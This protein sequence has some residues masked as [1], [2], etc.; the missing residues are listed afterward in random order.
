MA[1][2]KP[3]DYDPFAAGPKFTPVDDDPFAG[4]TVTP[5]EHDPFVGAD[6][7]R[8]RG[9]GAAFSESLRSTPGT[10]GAG[11]EATGKTIGSDI[12]SR[13]GQ[14]LEEKT[15]TE[16]TGFRPLTWDDIHGIGDAWDWLKEQA[17]SGIASTIPSVAS[18]LAGAGAGGLIG[19]VVP[20]VGTAA[21][22]LGGG[23]AGAASTAVP[24]NI[25]DAYKQF[26][27]EGIDDETAAKAGTIVG[28]VISIPDVFSSLTLTKPFTNTAKKAATDI[29]I[30]TIAQRIKS[31]MTVEAATEGLQQLIQEAAAAALG[32]DATLGQ[33]AEN[34]VSS[35][36][37]GGLGGATV[38]TGAGI[39][40]RMTSNPPPPTSGPPPA[41]DATAATGAPIPGTAGEPSPPA[42]VATIEPGAVVGVKQKDAPPVRAQIEGVQDGY[43]FWRDDDG[44]QQ[45]DKVAEFQ[46]D[47]TTAP[48][49]KRPVTA[50]TMEPPPPDQAPPPDI[51]DINDFDPFAPREPVKTR[52]AAAPS[53]QGAMA[54]PD[55]TKI[56]ALKRQAVEWDKSAAEATELRNRGVASA[57]T[58]EEIAYMRRAADEARAEAADLERR[59]APPRASQDPLAARPEQMAAH[60]LGPL[61]TA[62]PVQSEAVTGA[63]QFAVTPKAT[64]PA[65]AQAELAPVEQSEAEA[66][67][68]PVER[69][70][71]PQ[72]TWQERFRQQIRDRKVNLNDPSATARKLGVTPEEIQAELR[73]MA[74][75][76]NAPVEI[77]RG[78]VK[79]DPKTK[80]PV[81]SARA[82][83]WRYR[84]RPSTKPSTLTDLIISE[85]GIRMPT[86]EGPRS[87]F[88]GEIKARGLDKVFRLGKGLGKLF[89]PDGRMSIEDAADRALSYGYDIAG[90]VSPD[91]EVTYP[92][93]D[94]F[95]DML[96]DER[97]GRRKHFDPR[98]PQET[99]PEGP[100]RPLTA[101]DRKRDATN[102]MR[103]LGFEPKGNTVAEIEAE[104]DAILDII[105]AAD[106]LDA[107]DFA[108]GIERTVADRLDPEASAALEREA[109]ND[110]PGNFYDTDEWL[111]AEQAE[112]APAAQ[113]AADRGVPESGRDTGDLTDRQ[114]SVAA[115]D[116]GAEATPGRAGEESLQFEQAA[117]EEGAAGTYT[118][119]TKDARDKVDSNTRTAANNSAAKWVVERGRATGNEYGVAISPDGQVLVAGTSNLNGKIT[120]PSDASD[121]LRN[122]NSRATYHHN[123]PDGD[124][125]SLAD[126]IVLSRSGIEWV[127]A[128]GPNGELSAAK[129]N[130]TFTEGI[131]HAALSQQRSFREEVVTLAHNLAALNIRG[132]Y[133]TFDAA[134]RALAGANVI[135]YVSTMAPSAAVLENVN[136]IAESIHRAISKAD[137]NIGPLALDQS[138]AR[139]SAAEGMERISESTARGTPGQ[140]PSAIG[141]G[142]ATR[143]SGQEG[144]E[145][146]RPKDGSEASPGQ[147]DFKLESNEAETG[148]VLARLL[149][150]E[151]GALTVPEWNK[152]REFL[153]LKKD[154][155]SVAREGSRIPIGHPD[156]LQ[157]LSKIDRFLRSAVSLAAIDKPSSVYWN[158]L[159]R[160]D[161]MR[162][163]LE[164]DA[165][166][167]TKPYLALDQQAR[168]RV[169][170]VLEHDRLY[171]V[172]RK[173][174]G[175][176][177]VVKIPDK[178]TP[179]G[180]GKPEL[181]RP[182]E[183]IALDK[184]ESDA[185]HSLR[186]FFDR[187]LQ[188][189]G[190][191]VA[192]ERGYKGEFT[193]AGI[194][195]A[196]DEADHPRTKR[197][198][199][200]A[201]GIWQQTE[202][203]RRTGYVPF[204]RYGDTFI[205]VKPKL[206]ES[207]T[208]ET[209]WFELVDTKSIFD[210][211]FSREGGKPRR[212][213][214]DRLAEL[215]KRFPRDKFDYQTGNATPKSIDAL[216]I[217]ALEKA[218]ASLN[219][220]ASADG[221]KIVDELMHQVYEARKAG[222]R[223]QS[224]N[225]PGYCVVPGTDVLTAD[226]RW[227][228]ADDLQIGQ[229]LVGFDE[230][231]QPKKR[232]KMQLGIVERAERIIQPCYRIVLESGRSI[233]VS[234]DHRLLA[235]W[236]N[237]HGT[238]WIKA[239]D[240][241]LGLVIKTFPHKAARS[242]FDAGWFSG[243]LDGEGWITKARAEKKKTQIRLGW[244]QLPG[245]VMD[246]GMRI[247]RQAGL[248][249]RYYAQ[250]GER[251]CHTT[252]MGPWDAMG[253]LQMFRP[254]R[255]SRP[256]KWVGSPLP[257]ATKPDHVVEVEFVGNKT[258][259]ALQTSCATFIANGI[260]SHNSTDFE[261]AVTD[262]V[263][264]TSAIIS[265]MATRTEV[266]SA[267]DAI[268]A[269]PAKDVRDYWEKHKQHTEDE[270]GD[271]A[272]IRKFGFFMFL[273]GTPAAAAVNL[274]QTPLVTQMQLAL[275]AGARAPGL[276]HGAMIEGLRA[277]TVGKNGLEVDFSKLGKTDAEKAMIAELRR[278]GRFDPAIAQ[279]LAGSN[280]STRRA[281]RPHLTKLQRVYEIG[282]SMFNSSET[283]NRVAAALA[284]FRAAQNQ[285]LRDRMQQ[286]Y[287]KDENFKEMVGKTADPIDIARFG[288]DETQ[289]IGGKLNRAPI[290]RGVGSVLLQFKTYIANYLRLVVKNLTR[291]GPQ[292]KMVGSIMLIALMMIGGLIGLP[293]GEDA[294]NA[295]DALGKMATGVDPNL[296]YQFRS[297]LAD[298]GFGEYGAEIMTRGFGRD[299]FGIDIGGRLGMG[300]IFPDNSMTSLAPVVTG[301]IGALAEA[302]DRLHSGQRIGALAAVAPMLFG[303]GS[304]DVIKGFGAFPEE[305][306]STKRGNFTVL[307]E[308]VTL[309]QMVTRALGFQPTEATRASERQ[310]QASRIAGATREA[311]TALLTH[312]SRLIVMQEAAKRRNDKA[313]V[314][315][316]DADINSLF[317][318]N[319]AQLL[320]PTVADWQKIKPPSR[321]AVKSRILSLIKPEIAAIRR[322][323]KLSREEMT[324]MPYVQP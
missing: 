305:G 120:L 90:G 213:L 152:I 81:Q 185:L 5:V 79:I 237:G 194:Q 224:Q 191:A 133:E 242:D 118:D 159:L 72:V 99:E 96:E 35:M 183:I 250:N 246:R 284:Y 19:S 216:N 270:G 273:W 170:K 91:G 180:V 137:A 2:L 50:T 188:E 277:V 324:E 141:T 312:I 134:W 177:V 113:P 264:Q 62:A 307:P 78:S 124:P 89:R 199:E 310:Y 302:G 198:A 26:A 230:T 248:N 95:L 101:A 240:I 303:K 140:L 202:D 31:G 114:E 144:R 20:G 102:Q 291:M 321:Q 173:D 189:M 320:D 92:N 110:D 51:G 218:F 87:T 13:A 207:N 84:P 77:I 115:R 10:F 241:K 121:T 146:G 226:M 160:R 100:G 15:K 323:G 261:R 286:V 287:A 294:L 25:G 223:K 38:S 229:E 243:L 266:D 228:K 11:I 28:A 231:V 211:V 61:A 148:G 184:A 86:P 126:F 97:T 47:L 155:A 64:P 175:R 236:Q 16:D 298:A 293:G 187:R 267:Y 44:N 265:R 76:K 156:T 313:E 281:V 174:T 32:G 75:G 130:T 322:A 182:G 42:A 212:P 255:L 93:T 193:K 45:A 112:T 80:Q 138:A 269:H 176:T 108:T 285:Q 131:S 66:P 70:Q 214:L 24:L 251:S 46:R 227:V 201:Q 295:A 316:I 128:H 271:Y 123:H 192:R 235:G 3:V 238:R 21:G 263:R 178:K 139:Y 129:F 33:R 283:V 317:E 68:A 151:S 233:T 200:A 56:A 67:P 186:L 36:V 94:K 41:G 22:G 69:P 166:E 262:Y 27:S 245:P 1:D 220:K 279:D 272:G 161:H 232:R 219:L 168:D 9:F 289:F 57:R 209:A 60:G 83:K 142:S 196:I 258:V 17:G 59:I 165:I 253:C 136:A 30:K 197:I 127:V 290:M 122:P 308:D 145:A 12:M 164:R 315:A 297:F 222:L 58:P 259:I 73:T 104:L 55:T 106:P 74:V 205:L 116:E 158:A 172:D 208:P 221:T 280:L 40:E 306:I 215:E 257:T 254:M 109:G 162:A 249:I 300:N 217:P 292:G 147:S 154:A 179:F 98:V 278:E 195:K 276:A 71:A 135:D 169:N 85:G 48:P 82:G 54:L 282:A 206:P 14:W 132:G 247:A 256:E 301:T 153:R 171:G 181:S 299:A 319:L 103:A 63:Q 88:F 252:S 4:R 149:R 37:G 29:V 39:A 65:S 18:G 34:V 107:L 274:T 304:K 210:N 318:D 43:V 52:P 23:L 119:L 260:C 234:E 143:D 190:E 150:D 7:D 239:K 203:M 125:L 244:A 105:G 225:V 8:P 309:G 6:E 111:A 167:R 53:P 163:A 117:K 288:V 49:P 275:W 311:R 314:A 204:Q 268:Q 157:S 296:E